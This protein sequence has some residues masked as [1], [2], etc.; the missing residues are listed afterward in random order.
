MQSRALAC[1]IPCAVVAVAMTTIAAFSDPPATVAAAEPA[2]SRRAAAS[3]RRIAD[4][5]QWRGPERTGISHETDLLETWPKDGPPLVWKVSGLGGGYTTPSIAGGRIY[6]M[7][8]RGE[9]EVVWARDLATGKEVWATRI[10]AANRHVGYGEGSRST[11]TVD[12]DMLYCI[13]VSGDVAALETAGGKLRWHKNLVSDFGGSVPGWGYTESPLVDDGKVICTPGGAK[14][15]LVALDK[16]NGNALWQ[17]KEF[18]DGAAYSSVMPDDSGGTHQYV[19][20]TGQSVAGV[21]AQNGRL[22][23]RYPRSGPTAAIPTP[24]IHNNLVYA[25]SGY[26]AGCNLIRLVSQGKQIKLEEVYANKVMVNHHGG[27]VLI[28]DHIYGYSDGKGWVCQELVSGKMVWNEKNKLG[29]G[30]VAY[31][32]GRLYARAEDGTVALLEATPRGYVE[33]GRFNQPDRSS[34]AAWAHPVIAGGK[35]FLRDQEILLCY[36]VREGASKAAVPAASRDGSE[37]AQTGRPTR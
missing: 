14:G 12:G 21:A 6:G 35:L 37:V 17:S 23:W 4:W 10:A 16:K 33:L 11:P 36:D 26:G 8:Y 18:S 31:A 15:T 27:V 5:P 22:L 28:N 25:T 20:M 30:A 29:K 32:D 2:A 9:D 13:G 24:V 1:W 34:Q 7:G 19:Q 3:E